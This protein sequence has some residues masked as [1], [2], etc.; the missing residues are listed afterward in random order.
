MEALKIPQNQ[1]QRKEEAIELQFQYLL[2]SFVVVKFRQMEEILEKSKSESQQIAILLSIARLLE[3]PFSVLMD[4]LEA[5]QEGRTVEPINLNS[6]YLLQHADD[7]AVYNT[8]RFLA[9]RTSQQQQQHAINSHTSSTSS[10][11]VAAPI[12]V[13]ATIIAPETTT[14]VTEVQQST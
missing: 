6:N 14:E 8:R 12:A 11:L 9:L 10:A 5:V 3:T 4:R 7:T 2:L 1:F 13:E